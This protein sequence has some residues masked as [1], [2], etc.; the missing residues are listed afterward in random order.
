MPHAVNLD[1][2]DFNKPGA[3]PRTSSGK[4]RRAE[5]RASYACNALARAL[6]TQV[7]QPEPA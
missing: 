7:G 5:A 3:F 2:L 6:P 4:V 1:E